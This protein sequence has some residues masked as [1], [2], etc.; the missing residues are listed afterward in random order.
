MLSSD[1]VI[2]AR[3]VAVVNQT[4][5]RRYFGPEDPIGQQVRLKMLETLPDGPV[6]TRS[7]RSS[8]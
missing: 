4:L 2:G 5:V 6:P 7:S 1:D 3:K 8:A